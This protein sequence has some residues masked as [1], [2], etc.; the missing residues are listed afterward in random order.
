MQYKILMIFGTYI[1]VLADQYGTILALVSSWH[2]LEFESWPALL[3]EVESQFEKNAGKV[4]F[5]LSP[6]I[7]F[8]SIPQ[9]KRPK[10]DPKMSL[11]FDFNCIVLSIYSF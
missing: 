2:K 11:S 7:S 8:Q 9:N 10:Q 6:L 4:S 5:S 3:D 1:I